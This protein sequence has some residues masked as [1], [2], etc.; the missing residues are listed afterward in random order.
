V[1]VTGLAGLGLCAVPL[2]APGIALVPSAVGG[3]PGWLLGLYGGGARIGPGLYL[4]LLCLAFASYLCVIAGASALP[5]RLLWTLIAVLIAAFAL[6]PPLLSQDVFSYIS[7]ARLGAEHDL[8]PYLHTPSERPADPAFAHL[9]WPD[10]VSAYGPLFSLLTYPL[11]W[12]GVPVALWTMK[13]VA[14]VSVL[15]VAALC[16]RLA[17]ARGLDPR[18]TAAL[19]ALN[20]LVLVHVVGGAHNEGLMMLAALGGVAA[21]LARREGTGAAAILASAALKVSALFVAPFALIG[22]ARRGR[23]LLCAALA[24]AALAAAGT[25][26][27]G[28]HAFDAV[29]LAGE[30]QARESHRSLPHLAA[31]LSGAG[32]GFTRAAALLLYALGLAWLLRWAWRG[33]DWVRAAGWAGVGLLAASAW[34][35]PWYVLWPLP[36]AALSRDRLLVLAVLAFTALHLATRVPL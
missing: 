31:Q 25:I 11:G 13:A 21:V 10:S 15:G 6:A 7:Y 24:A 22:S 28:P 4:G 29:G 23:F 5:G 33:A 14:G 19:V 36:L 18:V 30:N 12:L 9:G 2:A 3:G 27:F 26:A 1:G 16:A 34:V 8:N 17:P 20:P 32:S 35:L